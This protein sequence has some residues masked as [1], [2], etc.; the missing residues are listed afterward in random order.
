MR[1]A[2]ELADWLID[3]ELVRHPYTFTDGTIPPIFID[4]TDGAPAPEDLVGA[5]GASVTP[6]MT[7][8]L[9]T[10]GGFGSTPYE[11]FLDR[12]TITIV[13]RCQPKKEKELVDLSNAIDRALDDKRAFQ[14]GDLRVEIAQL[15][16]PLIKIPLST[17]AKGSVYESEYL[18][19]VRKASMLDETPAE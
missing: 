5:D 3:E 14:M 15:Y 12:R 11:G 16:R 8:T 13:Y 18:F 19:L 9:Q 7:V 10:S 17:P 4:P 1:L 2:K 6:T